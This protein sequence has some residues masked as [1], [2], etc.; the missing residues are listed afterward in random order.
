M[1]DSSKEVLNGYRLVKAIAF[2]GRKVL[3]KIFLLGTQDKPSHMALKHYLITSQG[4]NVMKNFNSTQ[5]EMIDKNADGSKFDMSLLYVS[6]KVSCKTVAPNNDPVWFTPGTHMEY[7]ITAVKNMRNDHLHGQ[8][9]ITDKVYFENMMK[10]RELLTG[11]LKTSGEKYG[12]DEAEVKE[13][14]QQMNDELDNIMK[15][16]LGKQD[17]LTFCGDE[18]KSLM[19]NESRDKLK[20][21]FQSI[22]YVN[23]V[24]FITSNLKL[25]VGK[26]FVNIQVKHGQRGGEGE[27]IS[28]QHLLKL[29]QTTATP[30]FTSTVLQQQ[31]QTTA[32]PSFFKH[33]FTTTVPDYSNTI[34]YKHCFTTTV[35]DYSNTIIYKHCFTTTVPDYSSTIIKHCLTTGTCTYP[36]IILLEGVAGSGKTTL[37]KLVIYEWTQDGQGNISDLD[38]YDLLL[39]VQCSDPTMTCYQHLL[40]RLMPKVAIKFKEILPKL[41]K[42]CKTLIIIDGLD[43]DNESSRTLVQ[44]LLQEFKYCSNIAFLCTSR[45]EKVENFRRTIPAEYTVQHA[46]LHGIS[47]TSVVQFVRLNHQEIT[48][49]TGNNRNTEELVRKVS[50]LEGIHEH[51]R[52]PMNLILMIYIWDHDPDQLNL[53]S[54]THTELYYNIHELCKHKLIERLTNHKATKNMDDRKLKFNINNILIIIYKTALESLSGDQLNLEEETVDKLISTCD[55][56]CL[57]YKEVLSAFL[58]LRP[59][60]T[61]RGITEQYSAP[62]KGIQDYFAALYIVS[63]LNNPQCSTPTSA[64]ATLV[65][66]RGVLE[67]SIRSARVDMNK[68]QNVLIHVAGQLHLVL[69][70][71]PEASAREIV[72]L[73]QESGM[74]DKDQWLDLLDNTKMSPVIVK[75]I[76]RFFTSEETIVR[77]ERVRSY[78]ALLPHLS[79]SV[80]KI[81]IRGDPSNLPGLPDL[82]A[83]FTHQQRLQPRSHVE[84][85]AGR[86]TDRGLRLLQSCNKLR[87]LQLRVVSDHHAGS[88]LPQLHHTVTSTL[89]LEWLNYHDKLLSSFINALQSSAFVPDEYKRSTASFATIAAFGAIKELMLPA[90]VCSYDANPPTVRMEL[91][92]TLNHVHSL[93]PQS[94]QDSVQLPQVSEDP[95]TILI[96][97]PIPAISAISSSSS[98][99]GDSL[100]ENDYLQLWVGAISTGKSPSTSLDQSVPP[101]EKKDIAPNDFPDEIKRLLNQQTS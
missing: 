8:L 71:V 99:T 38:N 9:T 48:K 28:Y 55:E 69:D 6:I 66:I 67:E 5:K 58:C 88:I 56:L 22:S 62:H 82:L 11:C 83:A 53:T 73:L 24:S 18:M 37:V 98:S 54:V 86:L 51:L 65:S 30:S 80:V 63:S 33:C 91:L 29:V 52:L 25:K 90:S 17:I 46:T 77:N 40:E 93:C 57:P 10:L 42:L 21:I 1:A 92:T 85:F 79:S 81:I 61:V 16:I 49:Q 96:A 84:V 89:Q 20:E 35:P 45:P 59:T 50:K 72:H 87:V 95:Q 47:R 7:Y 41:M 19:I 60:W 101:V 76:S 43:E 44:S 74:R 70:Q 64:S 68:Y 13:E 2:C 31:Y 75:E 14:I 78:T 3:Y 26:I 97:E 94:M 27:H 36:H 15:E 4:E 32:T 100:S 34:I 23:P 12:R 39:W